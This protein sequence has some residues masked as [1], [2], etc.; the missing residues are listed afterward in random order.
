MKKSVKFVPGLQPWCGFSAKNALYNL[1]VFSSMNDPLRNLIRWMVSGTVAHQKT[2]GLMTGLSSLFLLFPT[3]PLAIHHGGFCFLSGQFVPRAHYTQHFISRA[4]SVFCGDCVWT[5]RSW[6]C[7]I[8]AVSLWF[9]NVAQRRKRST[10]KGIILM[11]QVFLGE[12]FH[13]N[14]LFVD[15]PRA[16]YFATSI[17]CNRFEITAKIVSSLP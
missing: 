16:F 4:T 5:T 7:G 17:L 1:T 3:R 15:T 13:Q 9:W 6:V 2:T 14:N 11:R 8:M 10:C 12:G